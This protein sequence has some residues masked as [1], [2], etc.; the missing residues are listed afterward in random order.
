MISSRRVLLLAVCGCSVLSTGAALAQRR[1][2]DNIPT[3]PQATKEYVY[4]TTRQGELKLLV[5][6]P[7]KWRAS[8]RRPGIVFF[9]GGGWSKG[10]PGQFENQAKYLALR[11]MVAVRADYRVKSRHNVTP[12]ACVEDAKSAMRWVRKHAGEL[13]IDPDKIVAAGGSAGG[14]LAACTGTVNGLDAEGEETAISTRPVAMVLFNPVLDVSTPEL[15]KRLEGKE[16]LARQISPTLNLT[17]QTP[18]AVLM[19]G[20]DDKLLVQAKQYIARCQEL[21]VRAELFTAEKQGP[22]FFN[23]SPWQER[24]LARAEEFLTSLGYLEGKSLLKLP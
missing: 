8:D 22:A 1:V 6:V 19:F 23:R 5:D 10:T 12:D 21:G 7:E 3:T 24:T 15:I 9:F 2:S 18:P 13:G 16:N 14:H 17:K 20:T 11:G 4:K